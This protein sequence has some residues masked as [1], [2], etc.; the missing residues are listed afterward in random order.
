MHPD[1][2]TVSPLVVGKLIAEQFPQ[3]AGLP[4]QSISGAG[5]VNAVFRVGG[6]VVARFPLE[7]SDGIEAVRHEL[8]LEAAAAAELRGRT[9]VATP[10]ALGIGEPGFGY[11]LPWSVFTW[12]PGQP[13][14][15]DSCSQSDS[16]ATDLGAF[17]LAVR[18]IDT[19][20]RTYDGNGRGGDLGSYDGWIELCLANCEGL[21]DVA[22]LR[23]IWDQVR[24]LPRGNTPD[25]MNHGDLIP[26]NILTADDHLI[27]VLDVGGFK[28]ADPA[29]DLVSA[30]HL[31]DA[32]RRELLRNHLGCDED[33]WQRGRGWAFQQAMGAVWY[34]VDSNPAMSTNS[35]RT[36]ERIQADI[37]A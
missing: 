10:V 6:H 35:R 19:R 26:P 3:W 27:G 36:L 16:F 28:A 12:L 33:E 22:N 29:L 21:L 18:A 37:E 20:G 4:I 34:Y 2:L 31:L 14:T 7:P 17:I 1:Q 25:V 5:T 32:P 8:E 13:A 24:V 23:A 15:A 11:P 30:W 9:P